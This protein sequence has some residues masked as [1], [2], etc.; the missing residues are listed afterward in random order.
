MILTWHPD[1]AGGMLEYLPDRDSG[2]GLSVARTF[3]QVS[4]GYGAPDSQL[5]W[6]MT[7][8]THLQIRWR[9]HADGNIYLRNWP[10]E[11]A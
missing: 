1:P 7:D 9:L 10:Q 8:G 2:A 6:V 3:I 11:A 4:T 5:G